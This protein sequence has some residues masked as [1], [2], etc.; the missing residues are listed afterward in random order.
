[1]LIRRLFVYVFF[2]GAMTACVATNNQYDNGEKF[3]FG[4][5][6]A[7]SGIDSDTATSFRYTGDFKVEKSGLYL[8]SVYIET[9][10]VGGTRF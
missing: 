10:T 4:N 9:R 3:V 5:V 8:L 1:M 2:S 6:N 7:I